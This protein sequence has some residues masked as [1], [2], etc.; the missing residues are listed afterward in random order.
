LYLL[1]FFAQAV[2]LSIGHPDN[3]LVI[4]LHQNY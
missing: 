2:C 4:N 1:L 3:Q